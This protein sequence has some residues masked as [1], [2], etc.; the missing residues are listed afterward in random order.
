MQFGDVAFKMFQKKTQNRSADWGLLTYDDVL[1]RD[2]NLS[3]S[4]QMRLCS[5]GAHAR[6]HTS[7]HSVVREE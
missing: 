7:P 3:A 5:H 4:H 2:I 1:P 6:T